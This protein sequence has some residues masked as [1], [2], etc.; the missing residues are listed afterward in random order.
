MEHPVAS[1]WH[2]YR[3]L[4]RPRWWAA[5]NRYRRQKSDKW[6]GW[7][8][9]SLSL[10]FA[11]GVFVFFYR[12]L[13]HFLSVPE[14]GPVL[15][16]KLLAMVF[17]TFLSVLLFS[18]V[19]T[20]LSSFYLSPDLDRLVAAPVSAPLF[21]AVR[22]TETL[23]E[24]SWMVLVFGLPAFVAYGLA[25]E[26]GLTFYFAIPAVLFPFV[27]I[28]AAIGVSLTALLVNVF[29]ARRTRDLLVLLAIVSLAIL[30]L[31]L[32]L[33]QPE[34]LVRPEEFA[35][36]SHFLVAMRTPSAPYLPSSW[37]A[38]IL[39]QLALNEPGGILRHILFLCATAA[40]ATVGAGWLTCRVFLSGF[41]KAQ[42]GRRSG[43]TTWVLSDR[44]FD[45]VA[46]PLP[47]PVRRLLAKE[48][49]TFFRDTSQWSQLIL[50]LALVVVYVYNFSVL[51][52]GGLPL[53]T[54][55]FRNVIAFLNL[56]LASFVVTSVALRFV[57]P[58]ISLEG[59]ALWVVATS[60]MPIER[61]WWSKFF[62]GLLPLLVLAEALILITNHY[63]R[64]L[65]FMAWLAPLT[66]LGL[67]VGITAINL[68]VGT[69]YPKFE[70]E[71]AAKIATG[72]GGLLAMIL[73]MSFAAAVIILQAWPTY[74]VFMSYLQ[75]DPLSWPTWL[76]VLLS[77]TLSGLL[78]VACT[79]CA[80]RWGL[81]GLA[82]LRQ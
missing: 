37:A 67:T 82:A 15:T 51:P 6:Q 72:A 78:M 58:A 42:E 21:F 34:R 19:V 71:H 10:G 80:L 61:L 68:A 54:F 2:R 81:T 45:T 28:P 70:A 74:A 17:L 49:R 66:M 7:L 64:V 77:L 31:S 62:V 20:S 73:C 30:Y 13:V 1:G 26:A 33:L 3:A 75:D 65:P 18:N 55:Y 11:A 35:E 69:R 12:V 53:V 16:Y 38:E 41:S 56:L 57:F 79:A 46:R 32:R 44:W 40:I 4:L 27:L 9:G 60:P 25:H 39:H 8:I 43:Y 22:F 50:L 36:F 52:L 23:L 63:L 47:V 14:F 5:R 76:S 59:K 29:P 48:F 24:S